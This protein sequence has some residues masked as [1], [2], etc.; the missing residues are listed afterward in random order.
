MTEAK[1]RTGYDPGGRP[2]KYRNEYADAVGKLS[3]V[4]AP[5]TDKILAEYFKVAK[6]TINRWKLERPRFSEAIREV[7][8]GLRRTSDE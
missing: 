4:G 5:C 8:A 6:S 3:L 7:R 1:E 2:T